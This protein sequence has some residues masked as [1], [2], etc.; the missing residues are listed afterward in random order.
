[1]SKQVPALSIAGY[2]R[3]PTGGQPAIASRRLRRAVAAC[4]PQYGEPAIVAAP[5]NRI[6]STVGVSYRLPKQTRPGERSRS[7]S[8]TAIAVEQHGENHLAQV[9]PMILGIAVPAE[10][11][12]VGA[13]EIQTGGIHEHE[14]EL[15]EQVTQPLEQAFFDD[16]P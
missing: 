7:R 12:P 4:A 13:L 2:L 8:W 10:R 15:G 16:S 1:M 11:L 5:Q 3:L 6:L 14:I 9:R